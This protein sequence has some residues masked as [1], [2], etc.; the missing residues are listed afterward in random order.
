MQYSE[1]VRALLSP[2]ERRLFQKLNSPKKIQ[3]YLEAIPINFQDTGGEAYLSPRQVIARNKAQCIQG[4]LLA[5]AALAYHGA[6][7]LL[8][9][10]QT[11]PKDEDH[12]VALFKQ[13]GFWGAISKTN[14]VVL[15][16]R[17]PV[18]RTP[19]ELAMSYF[20][21]YYLW[22]GKKSMR[23]Y[24]KPFDLRRYPVQ[25]WL[26]TKNQK[27]LKQLEEEL[28]ASPHVVVA[29]KKMLLNCRHAS[30]IELRALELNDW[31]DTRK[32]RVG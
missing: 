14:H 16:W 7:P 1:K 5:A 9:D 24:S 11:A 4:A 19:R 18:Y 30:P 12:V 22:S 15:R 3:T 6:P 32:K 20:N 25:F 21:E 10:F 31:K 8:M 2:A 29:T 17:D 13:N 26:T 23:G 28:D 27:D